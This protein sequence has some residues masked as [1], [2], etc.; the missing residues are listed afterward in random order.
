MEEHFSE[1]DLDFKSQRTYIEPCNSTLIIE[2]LHGST[3]GGG[4]MRCSP[5]ESAR[6]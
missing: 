3:G 6:G 4:I 2:W 5:A 1:F